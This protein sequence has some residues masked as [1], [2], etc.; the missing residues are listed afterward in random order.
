MNTGA[1]L[2]ANLGAAQT[3]EMPQGWTHRKVATALAREWLEPFR[4]AVV[5][6]SARWIVQ[7]VMELPAGGNPLWE[8]GISTEEYERRLERPDLTWAVRAKAGRPKGMILARLVLNPER[9]NAFDM[10]CSQDPLPETLIDHDKMADFLEAHGSEGI[11]GL[12]T[13]LLLDHGFRVV[14]L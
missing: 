13:G 10:A 5:A 14:S 1:T 3:F 9:P 2:V 7:P 8:P 6:K 4:P 11:E 12:F